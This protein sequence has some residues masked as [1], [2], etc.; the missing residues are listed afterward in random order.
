VTNL[1]E[2]AEE[3]RKKS[4]VGVATRVLD[5]TDESSVR[6]SFEQLARTFGGIDILISNAGNAVQ[7][8]I[9][10]V[11]IKT[12]RAS[13]ELNF[14]AHQVLASEALRLFLIQKSG[15]VLLFNASCSS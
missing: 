11:D 4:K 14:F 10:E 8:A 15:G 3:I 12:L 6:Q 5:V 13:F 1:D 9:G 7:G 2:V